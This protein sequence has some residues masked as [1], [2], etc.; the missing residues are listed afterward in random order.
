MRIRS[1]AHVLNSAYGL[2][3]HR[4]MPRFVEDSS[5]QGHLLLC[6]KVGVVQLFFQKSKESHQKLKQDTYNDSKRLAWLSKT[7]SE[8]QLNRK[9]PVFHIRKTGKTMEELLK[10]AEKGRGLFPRRNGGPHGG[11]PG[12]SDASGDW[13]HDQT[14]LGSRWDLLGPPGPPNVMFVALD[15]LHEY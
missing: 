10:T 2:R 6:Q 15:S 13:D 12:G 4:F 5:A 1:E 9:I 11:D 3:R 8:K 7:L 14:I